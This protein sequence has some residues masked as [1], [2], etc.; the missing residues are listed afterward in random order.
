MR[1]H[2]SLLLLLVSLASA[3]SML[4][5]TP[6][7][8]TFEPSRSSDHYIIQPNDVLQIFVYK[9][10][11]LSGK[12]TVL[13]DGRISIPLVQDMKAAGLNPAQLKAKLEA[14]LKEYLDIPNVTVSVDAIQSYKIYVTGKVVKGGVITLEKP[15]TVLQALSIAGGLA[16]FASPSEIVVVRNS[17]EDSTL[18][19]INYPELIKGK[20]FS[21]NMLLRSGD[22]LVVP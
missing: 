18:F 1:G 14:A 8:P 16:D 12:V 10:P 6:E 21:Q 15:I 2:I 4:A 7:N 17:G 3:P 11:A 20:N 13:P 5:Q 19:K 9:E 22:V